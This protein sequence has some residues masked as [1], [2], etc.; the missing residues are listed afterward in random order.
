MVLP[1]IDVSFPPSFL[2]PLQPSSQLSH[3]LVFEQFNVSASG[4]HSASLSGGFSSYL[5]NFID[6]G[7]IST[8][9]AFWSS[10]TGGPF[11]IVRSL[12][13]AMLDSIRI[14]RQWQ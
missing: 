14:E 13:R 4:D 2:G 10:R 1:L 8:R 9:A 3:I 11:Y 12:I 6:W 5:D 7:V